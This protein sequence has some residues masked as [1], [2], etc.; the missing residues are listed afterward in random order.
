MKDPEK[1]RAIMIKLLVLIIVVLFVIVS[2]LGLF[3]HPIEIIVLAIPLLTWQILILGGQSSKW[4][5]ISGI[6][7]IIVLIAEI[8]INIF[9]YHFFG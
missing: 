4:I 3:E 8:F 5:L 7:T 1:K 9:Y 6:M 2:L